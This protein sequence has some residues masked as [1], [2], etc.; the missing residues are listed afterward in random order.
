MSMSR[1]GVLVAF[2]SGVAGG[3]HNKA[4]VVAFRPVWRLLLDGSVDFKPPDGVHVRQIFAPLVYEYLDEHNKTPIKM[5]W[6]QNGRLDNPLSKRGGSRPFSICFCFFFWP[7]PIFLW[8]I[9]LHERQF[10]GLVK[11]S[12]ENQETRCNAGGNAA[13]DGDPPPP[14]VPE[15]RI[16]RAFGGGADGKSTVGN[17]GTSCSGF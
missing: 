8:T 12:W 10:R 13:S 15:D 2:C 4:R 1:C 11:N 3:F 14:C 9:P 7:I 17:L 5:A 6:P 16:R